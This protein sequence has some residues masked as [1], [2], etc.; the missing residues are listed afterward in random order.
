M[1]LF[2]QLGTCGSMALM[3]PLLWLAGCAFA[4]GLAQKGYIQIRPATR[5]YRVPDGAIPAG[6]EPTSDP[7]TLTELRKYIRVWEL[8]PGACADFPDAE[9]WPWSWNPFHASA[10]MLRLKQK[11]A[12]LGDHHGVLRQELG[13]GRRLYYLAPDPL[14]ALGGRRFRVEEMD[15]EVLRAWELK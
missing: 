8:E 2:R 15:G 13:G 12:F 5:A 3:G 9:R 6:G 7:L 4:R 10:V 1:R 14:A 11:Q